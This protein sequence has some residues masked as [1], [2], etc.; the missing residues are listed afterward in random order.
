MM[1]HYLKIQQY[2]GTSLWDKKLNPYSSSI[3][4]YLSVEELKTVDQIK[5]LLLLDQNYD[6]ALRKF[7]TD[8]TNLSKALDELVEEGFAKKIQGKALAKALAGV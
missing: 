6:S 7:S 3:Y 5:S 8:Y 1:N 4:N 2:P